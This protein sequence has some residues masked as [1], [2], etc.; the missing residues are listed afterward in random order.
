M[1]QSLGR[2]A[3]FPH[4]ELRRYARTVWITPDGVVHTNAHATPTECMTETMVDSL[5]LIAES[6]G[7]AASDDVFSALGELSDEEHSMVTPGLEDQWI[8]DD[9]LDGQFTTS[10]E[11]I[12]YLKSVDID[13]RYDAFYAVEDVLA[14]LTEV[15]VP[16]WRRVFRWVRLR[17][18]R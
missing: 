1:W 17:S 3:D 2:P 9:Y 11:L 7:E 16:R 15:A 8:P 18:S 12:D 13:W 6:E 14:S 4:T 10:V 5:I